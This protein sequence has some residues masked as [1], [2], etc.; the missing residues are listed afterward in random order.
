MST[1]PSCPNS[2]NNRPQQETR[3]N[4]IVI[5]F[6][7]LFGDLCGY[8]CHTF[9]WRGCYSALIDLHLSHQY[10]LEQLCSMD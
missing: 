2:P 9:W 10:E 1:S 5:Q 7:L 3:L 6:A 4:E 8:C